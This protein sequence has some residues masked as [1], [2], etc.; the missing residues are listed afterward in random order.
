MLSSSSSHHV[1]QAQFVASLQTT[2][3]LTFKV[4]GVAKNVATMLI[5]IGMGESITAIQG[6]GYCLAT[7][8]TVYYSSLRSKPADVTIAKKTA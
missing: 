5:G 7:C 4:A 2:S 8:A 3:S 1:R 6:L